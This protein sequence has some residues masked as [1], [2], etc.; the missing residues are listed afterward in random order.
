M[1]TGYRQSKPRCLRACRTK[2]RANPG[3]APKLSTGS[4]GRERE[5]A[6]TWLHGRRPN[7]RKGI[8]PVTTLQMSTH[9]TQGTIA[10]IA[11]LLHRAADRAARQA[12]AAGPRSQLHV[13][14]LGIQIAAAEVA[15]LV[16]PELDPYWPPPQQDDPLQLLRVAEQLARIVPIQ[17]LAG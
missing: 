8:T 15:L 1:A 7:E 10:A 2:S 17:D 5:N 12:A 9:D 6:T 4:G 14:S 16:R 11:R 13:L 3:H